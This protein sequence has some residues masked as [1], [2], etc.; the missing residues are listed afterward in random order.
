MSFSWP[1]G[2]TVHFHQPFRF[3]CGKIPGSLFSLYFHYN[4]IDPLRLLCSFSFLESKVSS[5]MILD[6][7]IDHRLT[8]CRHFS[9]LV[10]FKMIKMQRES[11][12]APP[13]NSRSSEKF[14]PSVVAL[15][16]FGVQGKISP[17]IILV[18]MCQGYSKFKW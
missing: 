18:E 12:S 4:S 8:V 16:Q 10:T 13:R 6:F 5:Q 14:Y 1:C 7:V 17:L 9:S 15:D 2:H 3:I 11:C